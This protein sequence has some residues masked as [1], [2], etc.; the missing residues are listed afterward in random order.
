MD[1]PQATEIEKHL[2]DA[3]DATNRA[4][5]VIRILERED[6]AMFAG[7]LVEIDS[8][9]HFDLLRAVY[10]LHPELQ[11]PSNEPPHIISELRWEDVTLPA[12]VS[13]A[14]L[15][16]IILSELKPQAQKTAMV[17]L[18]TLNRCKERGLPVKSEEIAA[19]LQALAESDDRIK[20]V[21]D[22]RM[23]RHSEVRLKS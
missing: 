14:D 9:L 22:I 19:R 11:P 16:S 17:V 5:S 13:E 15:D 3:S 23:W 7:P 10:A 8:C 2:R 6:H 12:S 18:R 1:E 20:H 4:L 21:G